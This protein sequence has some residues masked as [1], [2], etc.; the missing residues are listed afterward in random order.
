MRSQR[1]AKSWAPWVSRSTPKPG[2]GTTT[3]LVGKGKCPIVDTWW[4]TE[5]GG[6]LM[7]PLP[8]AHAMKP[9]SAM[10]PFFGIE[11]VVLDPQSGSRSKAT[12]SK[13]FFAS[14]T[15]GPVRCAP[16]GAIMSGS[17]RPI[18]RTTKATT[19]PATAAA[20]TKDGDYWITGR[21]DDVINVS[22]HRMGT[23]EVESALVA[24][25]AVAEAAV[26]GY[27]A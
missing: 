7:T 19:S 25:A 11:P 17:R 5:T 23:A 14:R 18:S 9:G 10:K 26:V 21:V 16:S 2:T 22:G 15:A 4:Q 27:P 3:S 12:V 13:A 24:H 6:H 20:A 1:P 8:G